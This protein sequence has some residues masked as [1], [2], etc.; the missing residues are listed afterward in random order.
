MFA[1][2]VRQLMQYHG[3]DATLITNGA[4]VRSGLSRTNTEV[5]TAVRIAFRTDLRNNSEVS[6]LVAEGQRRAVLAGEGLAVVPIK[7]SRIVLADG[8]TYNV[9]SVDTQRHRVEVVAYLLLLQ[10]GSHT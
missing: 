6:S 3:E 10:G 1:A 4:I 2:A 8:T 5:S 7:N 9:I